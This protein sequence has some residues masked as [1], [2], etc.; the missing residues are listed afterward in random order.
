MVSST[1]SLQILDILLVKIAASHVLVSAAVATLPRWYA[2]SL[3]PKVHTEARSN[4]LSLNL[5]PSLD[6]FTNLVEVL[7]RV[8]GRTK[9]RAIEIIEHQVHIFSLL[10]LQIVSNL[11]ITVNL[12]LYVRVSLPREGSWLRKAAL[13][14]QLLIRVRLLTTRTVPDDPLNLTRSTV[15]IDII[16]CTICT[17]CPSKVVVPTSRHLLL[18]VHLSSIQLFEKV[19]FL[20]LVI[21]HIESISSHILLLSIEVIHHG[22][23][24][25]VRALLQGGRIA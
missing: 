23:S 11:N 6:L 17:T 22:K 8:I 15:T 18:L 25:V 12:Y 4:I 7:G 2:I 21:A 14:H 1:S 20:A 24:V 19:A 5:L 9:R 16:Y 10:I 3:S 13:M